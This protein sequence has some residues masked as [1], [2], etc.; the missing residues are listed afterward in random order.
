MSGEG[1]D[2][3]EVCTFAD[4]SGFFFEFAQGA[5]FG[6]FSAFDE[7]SGEGP[8]PFSGFHGTLNH[9]EFALFV[10]KEAAGGWDGVVIVEFIA[11]GAVGPNGLSVVAFD[12]FSTAYR[13]VVP[14]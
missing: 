11:V 10:C 8:E 13:A 5:L 14:Y 6:G 4:E 7:S 1:T 2:A 12:E 9:E 3:E